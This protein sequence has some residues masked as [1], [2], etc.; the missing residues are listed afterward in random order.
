MVKAFWRHKRRYGTR[1]LVSE[2]FDEGYIVGRKKVS[3]I[4]K[5]NGL[6]AIQL[7]SFVPK[8]TQSNPH[9]K[10]SPNVLL[11]RDVPTT[12]N[13]IWVGDITFL[14]LQVVQWAFLATWLDIF[15]HHIVGWQL[16]EN[17]ENQQSSSKGF[18]Y[19]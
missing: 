13:E 17:M 5:K 11:D 2:M 9:L 8:T 7:K 14:T 15:S 1:R 19:L 16:R 10:R 4:L 6:K 18:Q 3:Q 12:C